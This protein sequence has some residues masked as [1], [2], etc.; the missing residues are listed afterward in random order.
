MV[1]PLFLYRTD[2]M[3]QGVTAIVQDM[4]VGQRD[5]LEAGFLNHFQRIGR[6]T[7]MWS[8]LGYRTESTGGILHR[9]L[10]IQD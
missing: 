3:E 6:R 4:I 7:D 8:D 9:S 1:E 5:T 2:R 10:E